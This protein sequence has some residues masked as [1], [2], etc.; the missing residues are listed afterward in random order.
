MGEIT[1]MKK[2]STSQY[3]LETADLEKLGLKACKVTA[4]KMTHGKEEDRKAYRAGRQIPY[5]TVEL[6]ITE[7]VTV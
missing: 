2:I 3:I 4:T 6:T 1:V 7:E 5:D